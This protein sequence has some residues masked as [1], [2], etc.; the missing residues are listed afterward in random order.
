M[1]DHRLYALAVAQLPVDWQ[2]QFTQGHQT[3]YNHLEAVVSY[4][5][6]I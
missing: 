1:I 5:R 3:S 2:D 6:W 4:D